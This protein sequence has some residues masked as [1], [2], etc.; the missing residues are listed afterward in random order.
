MS[1]L[2]ATLA[3]AVQHVREQIHNPF[4]NVALLVPSDVNGVFALQALTEAGPWIR[5][6]AW[7]PQ[8]VLS[9]LGDA[10]MALT[11]RSPDGGHLAVVRGALAQ[12]APPAGYAFLSRRAWR[13]PLA[14]ALERLESAGVPP[15]HLRA[16]GDPWTDTGA[17]LAWLLDTAAAWRVRHRRYATTDLWTAPSDPCSPAARIDAV[18]IVGDAELAPLATIALRRWLSTRPTI[19]VTIPP[20]VTTAPDGLFD[21]VPN[22]L[23]LTADVPEGALG[24]LRRGQAAPIDSTVAFRRAPDDV[25]E[26]VELVRL[27][28]AAA[29]AGTPLDRI[30]IAVADAAHITPLRDALDAASLPAT[31]L[32]GPRLAAEPAGRALRLGLDLADGETGLATLYEFARLPGLRHRQRLG[33][34]P[35]GRGR[36][37]RLL[38]DAGPWSGVRRVANA[39]TGLTLPQEADVAPRDHLA[40]LL[41]ALADDLD[42]ARGTR[43]L[44]DHAAGWST[45]LAAWLRPSQDHAAV[46]AA[47]DSLRADDTEL[48]ATAAAAEIRAVLED[49]PLVRGSLSD[50]AIRVVEPGA[51]RGAAFDVVLV[52]GLVAGRL[53]RKTTEDPLLP[54]ALLAALPGPAPRPLAS[55]DRDERRFADALSAANT[56][57]TLVVPEASRDPQRP[58]VPSPF[59]LDALGKLDGRAASWARWIAASVR[60]GGRHQ[61]AVEDPEQAN[62]PFEFL[63]SVCVHDPNTGVATLEGS[64]QGRTAVRFQRQLAAGRHT[65]RVPPG[66]VPLPGDDGA[67]MRPDMAATFLLDPA[68]FFFRHGL[69][70]WAPARFPSGALTDDRRL[71]REVAAVW[72]AVCDRPAPEVAFAEE[73]DRRT[74]SLGPAE[75][76]EVEERDAARAS[77]LQRQS[78]LIEADR[79]PV[80]VPVDAGGCSPF[81]DLPLALTGPYAHPHH[82]GLLVLDGNVSTSRPEPLATTLLLQAAA[83]GAPTA[84]AFANAE[85]KAV[86]VTLV[87][88]LDECRERAI[89]ALRNRDVGE[90]PWGADDRLRLVEEAP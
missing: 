27:A 18:V 88:H 10:A 2:S 17:L 3:A 36:W 47:L 90:W 73:W 16:L 39:L 5:V 42:A 86:S 19:R 29:L 12:S 9:S 83:V 64:E 76:S 38:R 15:A 60:L 48:N 87:K 37:R 44:G 22:A 4:G 7:T 13:A 55:R 70:A 69:E 75:P 28:L 85:G 30:A 65:P 57:L 84:R 80:G 68:R 26:A 11:D 58:L 6:S 74:A 14:A 49:T 34:P 61:F 20:T 79:C 41:L 51:L 52:G 43:R 81:Q 59:V 31:L 35:T 63:L 82:D 56:Q 67:P 54:D 1:P 53:P 21:L 45:W 24:A 72:N 8:A 40:R 23:T 50:R 33:A 46:L 78:A 62:H 89:E 25:R 77:A 71:D 32:V 66:T